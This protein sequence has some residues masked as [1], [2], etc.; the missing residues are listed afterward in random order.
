MLD[1]KKI[2]VA[3]DDKDVVE[4]Y[5]DFFAI[6]KDTK[7]VVFSYTFDLRTTKE[8]L[9]NNSFHVLLL[10]LGLGDYTPPPGLEI[11]K[12]YAKKIRIVVISAYSEY[13]D[14]CLGMGAF[15]FLPKPTD[16]SYIVEVFKKA[17]S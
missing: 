12:E 9:N 17:C 7:N 1:G 16:M 15:E 5:Q 14:E 3:E 8:A 13:K 4:M 6:K 11:L 10:D 2:L